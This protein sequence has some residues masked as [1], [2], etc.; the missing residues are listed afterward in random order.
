M[1][2]HQD[3]NSYLKGM[4]QRSGIK[5]FYNER[6]STS[7]SFTN[8]D[9]A[10][11]SSVTFIFHPDCNFDKFVFFDEFHPTKR[12]HERVG[13]ALSAVIPEFG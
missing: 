8:S 10:C 5:L 12:I 9:D 4:H 6:I 7:P 11:F 13:R 3:V 2:P 1:L